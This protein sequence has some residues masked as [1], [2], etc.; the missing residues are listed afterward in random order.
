MWN[1]ILAGWQDAPN[2]VRAVRVVLAAIWICFGALYKVANL[3]PRHRQIVAR[4]VGPG[5]ARWLTPGIGLAEIGLGLWVA[6][7]LYPIL[8]MTVMTCAIGA[9]NTIEIWRAKNLLV[10]PVP[11]VAGNALML[12]VG[13][14][15][16]LQ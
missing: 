5:T 1:E 6:S 10:A 3:V 13:W 7:G 11:M 8:C 14:W 15:A 2:L 4:I 9:M 12:A 16:A